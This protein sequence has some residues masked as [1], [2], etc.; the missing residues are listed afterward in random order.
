MEFTKES[1]MA[2][3]VAEEIAT[4]IAAGYA[5]ATKKF[6]PKTRFDEVIR[7][8]DENKRLLDESNSK[9]ADLSKVDPK[10][11]QEQITKLQGELSTAK[12]ES[13]AKLKEER[14]NSAVKLAITSQVHDAD[15]VISQIDM[16]KVTVLDDGTVNGLDTQLTDLKTKKSFLFTQTEG[17]KPGGFRVVGSTPPDSSRV[18]N[19]GEVGGSL[20]ARLAKTKAAQ[21]QQAARSEQLYFKK[22]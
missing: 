13:D 15:L 5:D 19:E 6:I 14:V 21:N 16:S 3:G 10:E 7:E 8:R 22:G 9:V 11:L 12:T 18:F 2:M 4:K 1:L 17:E 20:G